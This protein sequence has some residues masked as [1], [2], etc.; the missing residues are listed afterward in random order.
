[1]LSTYLTISPLSKFVLIEDCLEH[2][3]KDLLESILRLQA[4]HSWKIRYFQFEGLF[5]N[6]P[7]YLCYDCVSNCKSWL[8]GHIDHFVNVVDIK[9]N[10][11]IVI[12]SLVHAVHLYGFKTVYDILKRLI[13]KREIFE[14]VAVFHEDLDNGFLQ[15]FRNL[16]TFAIQLQP[17]SNRV[18]YFYKKPSGKIIR[19]TETY[20]TTNNGILTC[21]KIETVDPKKLVVQAINNPENLATFKIVLNDE[22]KALRDKVVLPYLY[23]DED[24]KMDGKIFYELDNTDD[25]DEEDPDDDLDI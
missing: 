23:R 20:S 3:G 7:S 14:I 11:I 8:Q 22:E 16:S 15:Y 9:D 17:N 13:S 18:L 25:W 5:K 19:Q 4:K 12:D 2:K 6:R 10:T 24:E 21:E 1:M